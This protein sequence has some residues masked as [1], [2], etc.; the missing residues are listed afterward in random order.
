MHFCGH[1]IGDKYHSQVLNSHPI[2]LQLNTTAEFLTN[3]GVIQEFMGQRQNAMKDYQAAIS[4]NPTYSLAYFNAG[5][6]YFH[7]RQ[8]AQVIR[9]FLNIFFLT[10]NAFFAMY[11]FKMWSLYSW[12]LMH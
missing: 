11:G 12:L 9:V 2:A 5:N 3:R 10:L 6:I 1:E 7:H 4:L 8:F